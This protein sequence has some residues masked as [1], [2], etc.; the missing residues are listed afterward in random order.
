MIAFVLN[1][2]ICS[3]TKRTVLYDE[4]FTHYTPKQPTEAEVNDLIEQCIDECALKFVTEAP[5]AP[6]INIKNRN[7]NE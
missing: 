7:K 2:I 4:D 1:C 5:K 6:P 3:Q